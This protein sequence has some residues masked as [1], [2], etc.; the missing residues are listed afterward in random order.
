MDFHILGYPNAFCISG[1]EFQSSVTTFNALAKLTSHFYCGTGKYCDKQDQCN[2]VFN[3]ATIELDGYQL[4]C[5]DGGDP[6]S[7]WQLKGIEH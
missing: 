3:N 5:T 1:C 4:A 7:V 6:V 2:F